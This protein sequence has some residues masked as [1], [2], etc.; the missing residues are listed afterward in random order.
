MKLN[1]IDILSETTLEKEVKF[2]SYDD[3]KEQEIKWKD[4]ST[5]NTDGFNWE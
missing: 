1:K 3:K 2:Y 5:L 4:T